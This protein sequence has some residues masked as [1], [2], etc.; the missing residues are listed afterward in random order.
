MINSTAARNS[1]KTRGTRELRATS[2]S[3]QVNKRLK[4]Y[5]IIATRQTVWRTIAPNRHGRSVIQRRP[6][7]IGIKEY[8][9]NFSVF[10]FNFNQDAL[11]L[12]NLK[13]VLYLRNREP[14]TG[15]VFRDLV[16]T[17]DLR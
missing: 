2:K 4:I 7:G 3:F 8:G 6:H 9:R 1:A 13:R 17:V 5:T 10:T 15:A 14:V 11:H 16:T 12:G